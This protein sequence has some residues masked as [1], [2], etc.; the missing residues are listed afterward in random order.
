METPTGSPQNSSNLSSNKQA[1]LQPT[2]DADFD[3]SAKYKRKR[4]PNDAV[5]II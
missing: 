3:E 1:D 4:K 5:E 2:I